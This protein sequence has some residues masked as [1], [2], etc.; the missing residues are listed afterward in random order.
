MR[1]LLFVIISVCCFAQVAFAVENV[2][3]LSSYKFEKGTNEKIYVNIDLSEERGGVQSDMYLPEGVAIAV[4]SKGKLQAK[5]CSDG[6]WGEND[7]MLAI[8]NNGD[9]Y[10]FLVTSFSG[11]WLQAGSGCLFEMDVETSADAVTGPAKV[12]FKNSIVTS[13]VGWD[14][15]LDDV[16]YNAEIVDDA[17][18]VEFNCDRDSV[19]TVYS[20][21]GTLIC[22]DKKWSE[23]ADTLPKGIYIVSGKKIVVK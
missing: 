4:N 18:G 22:K 14:T 8:N 23:V 3:S 19:V 2:F 5:L 1:K 13:T 12:I 20:V 15:D 7:L 17:T 16:E 10:T 9:F 11:D 21:A 6:P